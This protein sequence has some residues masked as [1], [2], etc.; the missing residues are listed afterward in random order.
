M[1]KP[2]MREIAR[3]LDTSAVTVSKALA[4][5]PGMSDKLRK[6]IMKK[7]HFVPDDLQGKGKGQQSGG[8]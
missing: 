2:T 6:K 8:F 5:K 3:A 1:K 4:G 7:S